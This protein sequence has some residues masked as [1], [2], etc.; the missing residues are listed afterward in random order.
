MLRK[1][2]LG[3][4]VLLLA[5]GL[6]GVIYGEYG[7]PAAAA[8]IVLVLALSFERFAYK[9]IRTAAPGPGWVRTGERFAGPGSGQ[10]VTVYFNSRSGE[11]RYV[12]EPDEESRASLI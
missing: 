12:A 8:E 11:R 2:L 3:P 1:G 4:G 5:G 7:A 6:A 10:T 9:P